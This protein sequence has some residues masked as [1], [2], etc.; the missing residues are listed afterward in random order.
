MLS[1]QNSRRSIASG[2]SLGLARC[3]LEARPR[4]TREVI[5]ELTDSSL[6]RISSKASIRARGSRSLS[7][8]SSGWV[9]SPL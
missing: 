5:A 9:M 7:A 1:S 4:A 6:R 2:V 8:Y 3:Q